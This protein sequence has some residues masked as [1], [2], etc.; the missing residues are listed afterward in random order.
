MNDY[1]A[2]LDLPRHPWLE[3]DDVQSRFLARS[4]VVHPD[5]VHSRST[6][7]KS[8]AHAQFALLNTAY[9]TLRDPRQ[10]LRH[11]LEL[12]RGEPLQQL[13]SLPA[14]AADFYFQIGSLCQQADQFLDR[15]AKAGAASPLAAVRLFEGAMGLREQVEQ[16]QGIL[17]KKRAALEGEIKSFSREA[18]G[19]GTP[20][21]P[22]A[23]APR[24]VER[25]EEIYREFSYVARW[26]N[27]LRERLVLLSF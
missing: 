8:A 21:G 20:N 7:E 12:E 22:A 24:L 1:F 4:S 14:A 2:L 10:R 15:K 9:Q 5:R 3:P 26:Q 19:R 18:E 16:L 6:D 11:W 25:L 13:E 23:T 27:Q 17:E